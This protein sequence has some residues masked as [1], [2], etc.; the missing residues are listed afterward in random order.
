MR[1]ENMER[2]P[3]IPAGSTNISFV[4]S[5]IPDYLSA[6]SLESTISDDYMKLQTI[7]TNN[8]DE[9]IT[10]ADRVDIDITVKYMR[11]KET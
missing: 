3:V 6:L 5:G 10:F 11:K 7:V 1:I 9:T 2:V 8:S 4:Y